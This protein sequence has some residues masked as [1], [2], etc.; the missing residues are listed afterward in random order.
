ML[1]PLE[2]ATVNFGVPT[3]AIADARSLQQLGFGWKSLI[4]RNKSQIANHTFLLSE[5][6]LKWVRE[7]PAS[8]PQS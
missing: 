4:H 1:E 2:S 8:L 5:E 3:N 7:I 6:D